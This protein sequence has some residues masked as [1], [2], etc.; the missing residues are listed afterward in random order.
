MDNY[1]HINKEFFD[2]ASFVEGQLGS[3]ELDEQEKK[4]K[5][6]MDGSEAIIDTIKFVSKDMST[7][8]YNFRGHSNALR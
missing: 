1:D 6:T 3:V 2:I 5:V 4:I 7:Y 8:R